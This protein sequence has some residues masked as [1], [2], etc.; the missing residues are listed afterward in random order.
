MKKLMLIMA[1]T[2]CVGLNANAQKS[3][4]RWGIKGGVNISNL[5]DIQY[6]TE[7]KAGALIGIFTEERKGNWGYGLELMYSQLGATFKD[8]RTDIKEKYCLDYLNLNTVI[9]YYPQE[10]FNFQFGMSLGYN[11]NAQAKVSNITVDLDESLDICDFVFAA[12][13]GMEYELNNNFSIGTR[14]NL[15]LTTIVDEMD[16]KHKNFEIALAY[17]F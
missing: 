13:I 3:T 10:K 6:D 12:H 14:Y 1:I 4:Q 17:K 15:G 16:A 8:P 5:Y 11:V 2:I 9:K 7:Y